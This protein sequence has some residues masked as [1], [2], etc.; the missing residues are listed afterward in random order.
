MQLYSTI[1]D[2]Q[3]ALSKDRDAGKTVGFVPTM[4]A[5]HP[6]HLELVKRS[7]SENDVSVVSIFVNPTQFNDAN[8][9]LK[10][11]RTLEGDCDLLRSTACSYVFAPDAEEIYPE[12]DTRSFDFG[13]LVTGMEGRF[14]PGHFNG[15]AQVVSRLFDIVKPDKAYFGEKDFQQLAVVRELVRQLGLNLQIIACPI[16]REKDGLAM[17]SR[18]RRLNENQRKQAVILSKTL[19]E[20]REMMKNVPVG[21]L[22]QWVINQINAVSGLEVEYFEIVDG[23]TLQPIEKWEDTN[24]P[25]GCITVFAGDVRLIDNVTYRVS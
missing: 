17:S 21:D 4:G 8:D 15:V 6:G 23:T 2:L 3:E 24:Y 14:R 1:S 22:K 19:F 18:N 20:S 16:V 7:I 12:P 10:Y 9:L 25:V 13:A 5:L 11:P